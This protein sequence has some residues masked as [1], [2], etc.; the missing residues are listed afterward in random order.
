METQI[1]KHHTRHGHHHHKNNRFFGLMATLFFA[2]IALG[3]VAA[4]YHSLSDKCGGY[5]CTRA[6]WNTYVSEDGYSI[7]YPVEM[8][9]DDR[10]NNEILVGNRGQKTVFAVSAWPNTENWNLEQAYLN[11]AEEFKQYIDSGAN[12]ASD[13]KVSQAKLAGKDAIILSLDNFED[14]GETIIVTINNN[15]VYYLRGSTGQTWNNEKND[16]LNFAGRFRFN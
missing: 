7:Q 8:T 9:V 1:Y 15:Q 16:L 2:M 4:I 10:T 6:G 13:F 5:T 11:A 12:K 14:S 3:V